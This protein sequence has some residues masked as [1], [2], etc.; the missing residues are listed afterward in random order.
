MKPHSRLKKIVTIFA[1]LMLVSALWLKQPA[2]AS[3]ASET[4]I[5]INSH[6]ELC[7]VS[8]IYTACISELKHRIPNTG[9][10][11]TDVGRVFFRANKPLFPF[12]SLFLNPITI[13]YAPPIS[14]WLLYRSL[15]I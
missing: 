12:E 14:L 3:N 8:S 11:S 4:D 15:L 7:F 10:A 13:A 9:A 5:Q 1:L 2:S 6:P